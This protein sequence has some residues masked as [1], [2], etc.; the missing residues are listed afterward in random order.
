MKNR[1]LSNLIAIGFAALIGNAPASAQTRQTATIP[2]SFEAGGVEYPEGAYA[3][4]RST[5]NGIIVLANLSNGRAA[6][7]RTPVLSG[8]ADHGMSKLVF[9]S[10]GDRM[11]L[12]EVW[13]SGYP[14]MLTAQANK[15]VSAKVVVGMK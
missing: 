9:N 13:F 12:N 10:S 5:L 3:V 14:G 2:F 8:K 1:I 11:K 6:F 7:V 15:E 4:T